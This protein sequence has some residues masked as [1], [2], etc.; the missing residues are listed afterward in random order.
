MKKTK[1]LMATAAVLA[2]SLAA[3]CGGGDKKAA[4][5]TKTASNAKGEVMVYTSIYP[6]IID[7]MCKPNVA[8]A[9]PNMKVSWFQGG[10][11]KV[12]TKINGEIKADKIGA[13]LLMVA[14]PSFYLNLQDDKRLL[15]YV[16]PNLKDVVAPKDKDGAWSAVR[17]SNMV[18]A[19]NSDK[20]KPEDA[21]KSWKDLTDPKWKGK[22]AMPSPLLSGTAYVA[23][24]AL[25][26]KYGWEY[27]E[28]L[29]D[30]DIRVEQ[31][32][33]AIQNK[34][35]TGEYA[36]AMILE[37]N[38]LKIA[39]TKKE[40]L[41]VVYPTDGV[42]S[43]PSPIAILNTTKNPEGAK[44]VM[45]WWLSKEGQQAVVKGWMHSVRADIEPPTGAPAY[46]TFSD[47]AIKVN[48]E[49]LAKEN[50]QIK[51]AFRVRVME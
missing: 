15:N 36:A 35:L 16:S 26:D 2:M 43:V 45:D 18:I 41:K 25:A 30:N 11:E 21:P 39:A 14:D 19:Y 40:P 48:W 12:I 44:A 23:V 32:N 4:D 46:K 38:I 50:A 17:I 51:E 33:S 49:K 34:L 27:F 5:T 47:K 42:I 20:L 3:G 6:D 22:I 10:T 8:K 9:F 31:G 37:E 24:G 13:D 28:Q 7:N 1:W 29:R